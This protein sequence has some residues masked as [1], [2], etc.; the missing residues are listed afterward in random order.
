M[1]KLVLR[2]SIVVISLIMLNSF[3]AVTSEV[4]ETRA[5]AE[6][7]VLDTVH[8]ETM[9]Q[10]NDLDYYNF[11]GSP[12]RTYNFTFWQAEDNYIP[13][14]LYDAEGNVLDSEFSTPYSQNTI[15]WSGEEL[16][17]IGIYSSEFAVFPADYNFMVT[18]Y[19]GGPGEGP[20]S[21]IDVNEGSLSGTFEVSLDEYW[22]QFSADATHTY[23]I[24]MTL[25]EGNYSSFYIYDADLETLKNKY[26]DS[27]FH[28]FLVTG[29]SMYFLRA[30]ADF[31][32]IELPNDFT[33]TISDVTETGTTDTTETSSTTAN[34]GNQE[35][36]TDS[37]LLNLNLTL[38]FVFTYV[39]GI[40]IRKRQSY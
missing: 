3:Y 39:V 36:D 27:G 31:E 14:Y 18:E 28:S 38:S 22:Y 40:Q 35:S 23:N 16:Y 24:T 17:T 30:V 13:M 4:G 33:I 37:N 21:A 2:G 29:E 11:T 25:A 6:I 12:L 32:F 34:T 8:T 15:I 10:Y 19:V 26:D 9:T 5:D 1:N 20:A 7:V